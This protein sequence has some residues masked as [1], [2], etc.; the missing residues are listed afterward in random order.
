MAD[1]IFDS[2]IGVGDD[3]TA[4]PAWYNDTH[5]K[6][7]HPKLYPLI[8]KD[9]DFGGVFDYADKWVKEELTINEFVGLFLIVCNETEGTFKPLVERGDDA[10]F[11][12][13]IAGKKRSYN[14]LPGNIRAGDALVARG[15]LNKDDRDAV[16]AWN[17]EAY[18]KDS[19]DYTQKQARECDF[20]KYRGRGLIRTTGRTSYLQIVDPALKEAGKKKCDEL[21]D[22]ELTAAFKNRELSFAILRTFFSVK[23]WPTLIAGLNDEKKP[24][25]LAVGKAISGSD[26]YAKLYEERCQKLL[27]ALDDEGWQN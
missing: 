14:T 26:A 2:D 10:Y 15:V 5:V 8:H 6:K 1:T 23:P 13:K 16:T 17:G 9:N 7:H 25:F 12:N 22:A 21:T 24:G 19:D 4:F 18:P 11:F 3:A 27:E 20:Y